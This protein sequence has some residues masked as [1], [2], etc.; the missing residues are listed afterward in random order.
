MRGLRERRSGDPGP[1]GSRSRGA[2]AAC[3]A[4]SRRNPARARARTASRSP[5][6]P[7]TRPRRS[8]CGRRSDW[9]GSARVVRGS[10]AS[11]S[12]SSS[13]VRL[14]SSIIANSSPRASSPE[15]SGARP[16]DGLGPVVERIQAQRLGQPTGG[17]DRDQGHAAALGGQSRARPPPTPWSC[18]PRRRP[19]RSRRACR[20]AL[21]P[22]GSRRLRAQP[23]GEVFD[24][25]ATRA[26]P[27]NRNGSVVSEHRAARAAAARAALAE[28]ATRAANQ[29]ASLTAGSSWAPASARRSPGL[30]RDGNSRFTTTASIPRPNRSARTAPSSRASLTAIC[31]GVATAITPVVPDRAASPES[32]PPGGR[33]V[34]SA[35][36]S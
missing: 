20:P 22:G 6:T 31:S 21:A 10:G 33:P 11:S 36:S 7:V 16:V 2:T 12:M 18:R 29:R 32:R 35:R 28:R 1:P 8:R 25:R 19:R 34:R 13:K 14:E 26:R 27:A 17:V 5:C 23:T 24:V 3:R 30:K 4:R 15:P 9:R